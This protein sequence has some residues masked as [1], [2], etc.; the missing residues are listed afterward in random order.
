[1]KFF[2]IKVR[3]IAVRMLIGLIQEKEKVDDIRKIQ[4]I[5]RGAFLSK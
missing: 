2:C 1:M 3:E 4:A 5:Y